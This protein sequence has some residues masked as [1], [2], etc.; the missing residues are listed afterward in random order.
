VRVYVTNEGGLTVLERDP[1]NGGLLRSGCA[2][3]R[4]YDCDSESKRFEQCIVGHGIAGAAGVAAS[5]DGHN[6]YI[7]A[8]TSNAVA[9]FT[10]AAS[11]PC[12]A[13]SA[14][15]ASSRCV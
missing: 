11:L 9:V 7:A 15:T 10:P 3:S 12:D 8:N 1:L 5:S 13:T 4:G 14:N 6:V 2:I